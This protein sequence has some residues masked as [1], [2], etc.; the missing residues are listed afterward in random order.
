[1][2][3]R[4]RPRAYATEDLIANAM[5]KDSSHC[6]AAEAIKT[7][8]P[9]ARFVAVDIQT[10]RW[11]VPS[12]GKRYVQLTPWVVQDFIINWEEANRP[13]LQPF[14]FELRPTMTIPIHYS[15]PEEAKARRKRRLR[16]KRRLKR[17]SGRSVPHVESGRAPPKVGRRREFGLR[18]FSGGIKPKKP[19][20]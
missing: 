3:K 5:K 8:I 7:A 6:V 19:V 9:E 2:P 18:R 20:Q 17:Q 10:M 15:N 11:S 16:A 14:D 4:N 13:N 1:M 12:M